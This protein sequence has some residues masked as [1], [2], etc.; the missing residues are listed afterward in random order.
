MTIVPSGRGEFGETNVLP[1]DL[2]LDA[3]GQGSRWNVKEL[4]RRGETLATALRHPRPTMAERIYL[5]LTEAA[6]LNPWSAPESQISGLIRSALFNIAW[7]DEPNAELV[8]IVDERLLTALHK[9]LEE[10]NADFEKWFLGP[11]N[12]LVHQISKLKKSPGGQLDDNDV[13]NVL[14]HRGWN[15][16]VY[17][18]NCIH[19]Q[20][21]LFRNALPEPLSEREQ[22]LFDQR[23]LRQSYLA[24]LP[25]VLLAPRLPVAKELLWHRWPKLPEISLIPVFHRLLDY[26][27]TMAIRRREVDRRRKQGRPEQFFDKDHVPDAHVP[28]N[29]ERFQDIA[30]EIRELKGI[31]CGCPQRDWS[32]RLQGK[33]GAEIRILH[34]CVACKYKKETVLS[35]EEFANVARSVL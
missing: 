3:K 13:R 34:H 31:D 22:N 21:Y 9:H 12:S 25:L 11:K 7:A 29:D 35:R 27:G 16:Y 5:G 10:P 15:S 1:Q 30:S 28:S 8:E 19:A 26:Y 24:G 6:Q 17:A 4:I 32:A 18:A 14:L 23:Y 33:P 20:M 2:G